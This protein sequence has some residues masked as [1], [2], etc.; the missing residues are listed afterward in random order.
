MI[1]TLLGVLATAATL[2]V[3]QPVFRGRESSAAAPETP[4]DRERLRLHEKRDQLLLGLAEL[5]FERDAGKL[6][7]KEHE[8]TRS[9]L[10]AEA[11]RVTA[12]LDELD[13]NR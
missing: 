7:G 6:A 5:D 8:E 4:A 9:R 12:R 13:G 10:L 1:L 3:L 2:F 11:A